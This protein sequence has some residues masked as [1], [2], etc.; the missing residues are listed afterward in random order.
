[1]RPIKLLFILAAMA[2]LCLPAVAQSRRIESGNASSDKFGFYFETHLDPPNPELANVHGGVV[3]DTG[4]FHRYM[5]DQ[6]RNVYF[7]YDVSVEALPEVN[8]YR[9]T[10]NPLTVTSE[11]KQRLFGYNPSSWTPLPTPGWGF[12]PPAPRTVRGGEVLALTL[13]TNGA[14]GQKIVD[15]VTI[16]EPARLPPA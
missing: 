13:L 12:Q 6:E 7:G 10:F 8:A 4:V 16:Q 3:K 1:M 5:L 2:G 11:L 9:V 15:Y 14:T